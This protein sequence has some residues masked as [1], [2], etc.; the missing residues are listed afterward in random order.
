MEWRNARSARVSEARVCHRTQQRARRR[1]HGALACS[2][3]ALSLRTHSPILTG[4]FPLPASFS[5]LLLFSL[6]FAAAAVRAEDW[7]EWRGR[8]RTGVWNE[9]GI[10]EKFPESGLKVA[11]RTPLHG[12][13][14]GPAVAEGRVF[15]TDFAPTERKSGI[16][17]ALCLD[18]KTGAILWKT[19][20]QADYA[21]IS[22]ET[23]PRA[24]PTVDGER[25]YVLGA[26][27]IMNC[28]EAKTGKIVWT[29]DFVADYGL[30]PPV[31]GTASAPLVDGPR[32][33][34]V[35]GAGAKG[36]TLV[37][38]DKLTGKELWRAIET[39][40][41][42]GYGQPILIQAGVARQ[43]I[44]WHSTALFSLNPET[45]A[46]YW[47]VPFQLKVGLSVATPVLSG[48]RL[49]VSAF[50]NGSL[51]LDLDA[52]KP[53]VREVWRSGTSSEINTAD[54]HS[55]ICTPV[56]KDAHIYGIC[57]YGQFRCIAAADGARVWETQDVTREKA[58]WATGFIVPNGGRYFINN[59]RGELIIA[60]LRPDGYHEVSRTQIITPDNKRGGRRELGAVNW[61]HPAYANKH[62]ITR[63]EQ[64]IIRASLDA[65]D[66]AK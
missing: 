61:V 27:G 55:L 28:L 13:Y 34:C 59:D 58:R 40:A 10:V 12:G 38:F 29:K 16:E 26:R 60:D 35:A 7:P 44:F 2:S 43:L 18:E 48:S 15:V 17:R 24:T 33:I 41:E 25:V 53:A 39:N 42:P 65:A 6:G 54:L 32:V 23:G 4:M 50:Y 36:A 49:L 66:Y 51:M 56:I 31:W 20:W 14:S 45:G 64:E 11:W 52:T 46:I 21:G 3:S 1:M 19:E 63:N 30:V 9:T 8:G 62:I 22:Y 5:R 37:A 47:Q 57:A